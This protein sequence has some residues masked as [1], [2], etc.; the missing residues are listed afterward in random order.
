MSIY[1]AQ[2]DDEKLWFILGLVLVCVFV[3]LITYG[4]KPRTP[5]EDGGQEAGGVWLSV[6]PPP[7]APEGTT[8]WVWSR[9][10]RSYSDIGGPV[11][12][13]PSAR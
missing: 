10:S 8:C 4:L 11:C 3:G 7:D 2:Q 13:S 6:R 1:Q 9:G 5:T 12:F